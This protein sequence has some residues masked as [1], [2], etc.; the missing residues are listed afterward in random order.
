MKKIG[1][2]VSGGDAQGLNAVIYA[3]VTVGLKNSAQ[4]YG[5][6]KGFEG[7]LDQKYLIL[8][9]NNIKGI[10]NLGGCI[11]GSTNHGRFAAKAGENVT[12]QIPSEV[13]KQTIDNLSNLGI[14]S[15]IVVGGDGTLSAASQL[16]EHGVRVVGVPKSIDNDLYGTDQTFG[17]N[18]AVQ[19]ATDMIDRIHTTAQAHDRIFFIETMGRYSGWIAIDAGI[20]GGADAIL[21]PEIKFDY[22][23]LVRFLI[24]RRNKNMNYTIIVVG[25]GAL[26]IDESK[27]IK[28]TEKAGSMAKLAGTSERIMKRVEQIIPNTFDMRNV[29]LGHIQRGGTP[30]AFDRILAKSYGVEA[31][32]AALDGEANVIIS[33]QGQT[34]TRIDIAKAVSHTKLV[35]L[36]SIK[37]NVAR[38][39][40]IF[41]GD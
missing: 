4:I 34:F 33:L 2:V 7:I 3:A 31:M 19:I 23:K 38:Q 24:D 29:V 6:I 25:E 13:I 18:T 26:S 37:I 12:M 1:L 5:F 27:N 32:K 8:D 17:F 36:D 39:L 41:L 30:T 21:V 35:P 40:G 28:R 16:A 20:A 10:S 15:L 22:D 9:L 14:E 11:L